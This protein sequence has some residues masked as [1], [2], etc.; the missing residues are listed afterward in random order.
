MQF[1][2]SFAEVAMDFLPFQRNISIL[3]LRDSY[4]TSEM[5]VNGIEIRLEQGQFSF[6]NFS[7][8][9]SISLPDLSLYNMSSISGGQG[10]FRITRFFQTI[11]FYFAIRPTP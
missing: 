2:N 4:I 6:T 5:A 11:E 3:N 8:E 10:L 1:K 9:V 7:C